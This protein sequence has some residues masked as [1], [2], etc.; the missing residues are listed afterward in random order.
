[1]SEK[2]RYHALSISSATVSNL[3][4]HRK[5]IADELWPRAP[6]RENEMLAEMQGGLETQDLSSERSSPAIAA[7]LTKPIGACV[8]K[9]L[10]PGGTPTSAIGAETKCVTRRF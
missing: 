9:C 6:R 3:R 10:L 2:W 4:Q 5:D 1:M 7:R 8:G